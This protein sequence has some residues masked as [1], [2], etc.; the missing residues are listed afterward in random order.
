MTKLN[1]DFLIKTPIKNILEKIDYF[2]HELLKE[3]EFYLNIEVIYT[4]INIILKNEE[5]SVS[6]T[7][8]NIFSI[9][10]YRSYNNDNGV[11]SIKIYSD[12]FKYIQ[13]I[14]LREAF[15]CFIPPFATQM[16]IIG[17]F[18]NQKVLIDLKK[19]KSSNEWNLLIRD[20]LV[21]YEFI[22][23][24][25]D[26][27]EN[28]LRR[29]STG[30]IDSPFIF[31]FKYIRKNIQIIGEKEQNFYETFFKEFL[32]VSSKSLFNDEIIETIRVLD[33]IFNQVK[34]Y[35][36]LLDYQGYFTLFK[37][38]GVIE[39][40]LSLN[41][42]TESMHWIKKFSSLSPTYKVNWPSLNIL[43]INCC[44]KFNPIIKRSEILK[45][46]NELPFFLLLKESRNSFG[47]EID[48]Y[49][50]IPQ[51]YIDDLKIFLEKLKDYGYVLQIKLTI[52]EKTESFVNLNYFREYH[53]KKTIV[54][55]NHKFY[56]SKY[57]LDFSIV[58]G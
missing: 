16:K 28:F 12:F 22:S 38:N 24:E 19:L 33:K 53:D 37:E 21:N 13:F 27:L 30:N 57:E 2:F 29:E 55:R 41:R 23:G 1:I 51:I 25:L 5:S 31:F 36:A 26:R 35:S 48:G 49:F 39:T 6:G 18:I 3:I 15:N 7:S 47:F 11:L 8:D 43:S 40:S 9:G 56:D 45:F 17:I 46:I 34:Y 20:K 52:V 44:I 54:N 58:Y 10:V 50:V 4:K 42:F 32:L 14:M